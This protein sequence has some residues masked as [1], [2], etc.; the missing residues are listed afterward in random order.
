MWVISANKPSWE[1]G[2][3]CW[4]AS[5]FSS[6]P[7]WSPLDGPSQETRENGTHIPKATMK[8]SKH[9]IEHNSSPSICQYLSQ[10]SWLSCCAHLA[11]S[12]PL[13]NLSIHTELNNHHTVLHEYWWTAW[14]SSL[15]LLVSIFEQRWWNS[16]V[17]ISSC[18]FLSERETSSS[19]CFSSSLLRNRLLE[20][21][22]SRVFFWLS[23]FVLC[24]MHTPTLLWRDWIS[25][26][27]SSTY[28]QE[29]RVQVTKYQESLYIHTYTQTG[30]SAGC[31]AHLFLLIRRQLRKKVSA[32]LS[33][34]SCQGTLHWLEV[35]FLVRQ[36]TLL[37][38]CVY[39]VVG[40][41]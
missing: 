35:Y 36:G 20:R 29:V 34:Q 25:S 41:G 17:S 5:P 28:K 11:S 27:S 31:F 33:L 18:C 21:R 39:M 7:H 14:P 24:L 8:Q 19:S 16:L 22:F 30:S 2:F 6:L 32:K 23:S 13:Y 9:S 10:C 1:E 26:D 40:G 12:Q 3:S 38:V 4:L 37:C 15:V